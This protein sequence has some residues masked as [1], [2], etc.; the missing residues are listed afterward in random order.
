MI[1][2]VIVYKH[3]CVDKVQCDSYLFIASGKGSM[4][5]ISSMAFA[6][7]AF[8]LILYFYIA[9]YIAILSLDMF[10]RRESLKRVFFVSGKKID[11]ALFVGK[12]LLSKPF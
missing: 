5:T 8:H 6:V 10:E 12:M 11:L 2:R 7:T 1:D 9:S 4:T 3:I